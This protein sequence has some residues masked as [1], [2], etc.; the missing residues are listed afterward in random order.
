MFTSLL[1]EETTSERLLRA[2]PCPLW[3]S[4]GHSGSQAVVLPLRWLLV[5]WRQTSHQQFH[6]Q[7]EEG[8]GCSES[9]FREGFLKEG[10]SKLR[11]IVQKRAQAYKH[12]GTDFSH[13]L[14][15]RT[16]RHPVVCTHE[17]HTQAHRHD[18]TRCK[19]V[20][21]HT[22]DTY[23]HALHGVGSPQAP[24]SLRPPSPHAHLGACSPLRPC[25]HPQS[26][27][28]RS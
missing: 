9:G 21:S 16:L 19:P 4:L 13:V 18:H 25:D 14:C 11:S 5:C 15:K 20:P 26:W 24:W 22:Q 8:S 27:A 23:M 6:K 7:E 3:G 17:T 1:I 12:A 28:Q 10:T 2:S